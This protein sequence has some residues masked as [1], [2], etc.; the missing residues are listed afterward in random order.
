MI[1]TA[2]LLTNNKVLAAGGS[3]A[4]SFN[5]LTSAELYDPAT[6]IWT[7]TGSMNTAGAGGSVMLLTNG[8]VLAAGGW[9]GTSAL[10]D[11]ELYNPTTAAWTNAGSMTTGRINP[12]AFLLSNGNVLIMSGIYNMN[13]DPLTSAELYNP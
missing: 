2:T 13:G 10:T 12:D 3:S 4:T 8:N 11:A 6:G 7:A 9:S 1:H 5:A